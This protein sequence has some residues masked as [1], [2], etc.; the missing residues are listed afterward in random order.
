MGILTIRNLHRH[1][2]GVAAINGVNLD[3]AERELRSIIGPNGAG[4]TTLFNVITGKIS[5]HSGSIVFHDRDITNRPPHEIVQ[6]GICRTFQKSS[7]FP[8][9]TTLENVRISRQ[10]RLGGSHRFFTSRESLRGAREES[11]AILER[12]GLA[13]KAGMPA[14]N[15]S[16]GDQRLMEIGVALAGSPRLLLLD[17]P[18]AG[19][20]PRETERT[21][22]LVRDFAREVPVI[23]VEHD[24]EVVMAISDQISVMHQGR[25]I[26][27]GAPEEIKRNDQVREAYLGTED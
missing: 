3:F 26:A 8:G 17:E 9:L 13:D 2:G 4:K 15:L 21:V 5:A 12:L 16:H 7:F 11:L 1:F 18:T 19:M 23:L 25:I 6:A 14:S 24:M 22:C 20:S 10:T 27:E